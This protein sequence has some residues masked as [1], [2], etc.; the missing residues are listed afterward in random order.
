[1]IGTPANF[2]GGFVIHKYIITLQYGILGKAGKCIH[3]VPVYMNA[4]PLNKPSSIV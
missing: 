4:G 1:M 2:D 3:L